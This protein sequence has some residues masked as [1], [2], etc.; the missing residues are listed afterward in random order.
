MSENRPRIILLDLQGALAQRFLGHNPRPERI[1]QEEQYKPYLVE[2]LRGV[3]ACG[4]EVHLFT[5]RHENR[6]EVTLDSIRTKTRWRPDDAWF[7]GSNTWQPP[8][9][10]KASYLNHLVRER[11]PAALYALENNDKTRAM[12]KERGICCGPVSKPEHLPAL[13]DFA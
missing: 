11:S 6:K 2:F 12:F 5:V 9:V 13:A 1:R 8:P 10:V 4:W 3:Q 7:N